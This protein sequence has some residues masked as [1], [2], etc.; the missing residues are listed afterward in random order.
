[1]LPRFDV[2]S[3]SIAAQL[4]GEG[5]GVQS[6]RLE[7]GRGR[8]A[9][10]PIEIP[11]AGWRDILLRVWQKI[12]WDNASLVAAGIALNTLLAVFPALGVAVRVVS[13]DVNA[14]SVVVAID[15]L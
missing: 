1:M 11:A 6:G 5:V 3:K 14:Q 4:P 2:A 9:R 7:P 8:E 13:V 10:R 12:G 15:R